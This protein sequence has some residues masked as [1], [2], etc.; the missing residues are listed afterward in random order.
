MECALTAGK[1]W[2]IHLN[3]QNGLK[4]DQHKPFASVIEH[5]LG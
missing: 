2:L 4:F 1:L 3:D 5:L